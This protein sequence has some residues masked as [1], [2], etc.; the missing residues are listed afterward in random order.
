[1]AVSD[2]LRTWKEYHPDSPAVQGR[3]IERSQ[4]QLLPVD[5]SRMRRP[6]GRVHDNDRSP[7]VTVGEMEASILGSRLW[8]RKQSAIKEMSS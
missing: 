6:Y 7:L 8:E 5:T 4:L 1:M 3:A 2:V